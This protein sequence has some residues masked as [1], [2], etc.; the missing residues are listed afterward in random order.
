MIPTIERGGDAVHALVFAILPDHTQAVRGVPNMSHGLPPHCPRVSDV[1]VAASSD[2]AAHR[3]VVPMSAVGRV[4]ALPWATSVASRCRAALTLTPKGGMAHDPRRQPRPVR[5]YTKQGALLVTSAMAW[6]P[7]GIAPETDARATGVPL[8]PGTRYDNARG[9]F[10]FQALVVQSVHAHLA[11]LGGCMVVAPCG[12][13]KSEMIAATI[14]AEGVCALIVAPSCDI[15]D[16]LCNTIGTRLGTGGAH[17]ARFSKAYRT[18][19]TKGAPPAHILV[20]VI[21]SAATADRAWFSHIGI[22]IVDEAHHS[23]ASMMQR[24][25]NNCNVRRVVGFTAT[26]YRSD[27]F[28]T[29]FPF[30]F[31]PVA[32]TVLRPWMPVVVRCVDFTEPL[33]AHA[34]ESYHGTIQALAESAPWV[35][36]ICD[37]VLQCALRAQRSGGR[38]LVLVDRLR[39]AMELCEFAGGSVL[40][41]QWS[42]LRRYETVDGE[43][44][45]SCRPAIPPREARSPQWDNVASCLHVGTVQTSKDRD[46]STATVVWGTESIA[47]EGLDLKNIHIE[48]LACKPKRPQQHVGRCLR[49][50][51]MATTPEIVFIAERHAPRLKAVRAS[52]RK[53]FEAQEGWPVHDVHMSTIARTMARDGTPPSK[54]TGAYLRRT[55]AS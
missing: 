48:W 5:F 33:P 47:C 49:M 6:F 17:V 10:P 42:K 23:P 43:W 55:T 38:V 7:L 8:P 32:A 29:V 52:Q 22:I 20:S 37:G 28:E 24:T 25:L 12:M 30:L 54:P 19:V 36:A 45:P 16:Q 1:V 18:K 4:F 13:G 21:N 14:A 51:S 50:T 3:S 39:L 27:G 53:Y 44:R 2:P 9:L 41:S 35:R 31:G 46:S 11:K 40:E 15:A 26:P 34:N